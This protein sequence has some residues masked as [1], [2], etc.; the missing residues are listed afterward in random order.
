MRIVPTDLPEILII[1]PHIFSDDRGFFLEWYN[2]RDFFRLTGLSPSFV[3][4][5]HS[6]SKRN[7]LRGL[8]YQAM[9]PQGKLV[10]A[11]VGEIMD[12]AVDIRRGSPTFGKWI[13][14]NLSAYNRHMLWVPGGFAHGFL[15]LSEEAEVLYKT[16]DFYHAEDERCIL[17]NDPTL[18]I[19]WPVAGKP[20]ISE[21]DAKGVRL[22]EAELT[23]P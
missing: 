1:E 12:V 23:D 5:N 13:S 7:V 20:I 15:T 18:A 16:T 4:D 10:K 21:K 19:D 11:V 6:R 9:C 22:E 8:H 2:E 14:V 17:W 3:Q